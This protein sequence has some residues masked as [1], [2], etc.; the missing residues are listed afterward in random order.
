MRGFV[1]TLL[2]TARTSCR[3]KKNRNLVCT[4][5]FEEAMDILRLQQGRCHYSRHVLYFR[6]LTKWTASLERLNDTIGYTK[7]NVVFV[8]QRFNTC[9][10][11]NRAKHNVTG[12]AKW[13]REKFLEI[14][15]KVHER[16][17][18]EVLKLINKGRTRAKGSNHGPGRKPDG[19]GHWMCTRCKLYKSVDE[20]TPYN[21][22]TGTP[23][24][25]CR[26]CVNEEHREK[27]QTDI[28]AFMRHLINDARKNNGKRTAKG[29]ALKFDL[30]IN[31]MMDLL[32]AQ[33]GLC[34]YSRFPMSFAQNSHWK[35]SIE[36]IDNRLGYTPGNVI[37]ICNEFNTADASQNQNVDPTDIEG[38]AQ[39]SRQLFLDTWFP[40]Q[41]A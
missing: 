7:D 26:P 11:T 15:D 19:R 10:N 32:W 41:T 24:S 17:A 9:G 29:R 18:P 20:F 1:K 40:G 30:K 21:K 31:Y 4:L 25:R 13:S 3:K 37:L 2:R 23:I 35:C 36:R 39:W 22:K 28:R 12:S 8:A 5:T 16:V 14:Y 27:T 33:R 6:P 38:T 34:A